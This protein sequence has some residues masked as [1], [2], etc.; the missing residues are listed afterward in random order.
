LITDGLPWPEVS[1][2]DLRDWPNDPA[3]RTAPAVMNI[4]AWGMKQV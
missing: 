4:L 2:A 1:M 3:V